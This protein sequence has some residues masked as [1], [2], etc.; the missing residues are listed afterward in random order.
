[1][2]RFGGQNRSDAPPTTANEESDVKATKAVVTLNLA[3]EGDS[4]VLQKIR[5][6]QDLLEVLSQIAADA[7]VEEVC[8]FCLPC[9]CYYT[10]LTHSLFLFL[11]T[12]STVR[13]SA[14]V[15]GRAW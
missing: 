1:V 5:T 10:I 15:T 11:Q 6:L 4:T 14:V 8:V 9:I 13:R 3:I 7:Q 12:V 2:N